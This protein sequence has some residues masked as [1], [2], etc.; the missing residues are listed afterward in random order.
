MS[1][2]GSTYQVM[3]D[4]QGGDASTYPQWR[5]QVYDNGG[6]ARYLDSD[7]LEDAALAIAL[8]S[9]QE[10]DDR[11]FLYSNQHVRLRFRKDESAAHEWVNRTAITP[12]AKKIAAVQVGEVLLRWKVDKM[13]GAESIYML[14]PRTLVLKSTNMQVMD[15]EGYDRVANK[16]VQR[17]QVKQYAQF[18]ATRRCT[19]AVIRDLNET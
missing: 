2:D 11:Y 10:V 15:P 1:S 12:G 14:D 8:Q 4:L 6:T 18:G 19:H 3:E 9:N 7:L 16:D 13:C 5:A 17:M